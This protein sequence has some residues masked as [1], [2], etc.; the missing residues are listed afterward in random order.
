LP[1]NGEGLPQAKYERAKRLYIKTLSK[2][3]SE[4]ADKVGMI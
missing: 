4:F 3:R 1:K 2:V